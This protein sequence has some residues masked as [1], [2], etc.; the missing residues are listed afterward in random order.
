MIMSVNADEIG[1]E[2]AHESRRHL[3]SDLS[4]HVDCPRIFLRQGGVA[5]LGRAPDAL[6]ERQLAEPGSGNR[7]EALAIKLPVGAGEQYRDLCETRGVE[8]VFE[9]GLS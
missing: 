7:Y 2:N 9:R 1:Q 5:C 4:Q 3:R 6:D 8:H